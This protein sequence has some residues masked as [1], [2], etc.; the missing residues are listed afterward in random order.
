MLRL[1]LVATICFAAGFAVSSFVHFIQLDPS[2]VASESSIDSPV[3]PT[4]SSEILPAASSGQVGDAIPTKKK[5]DELVLSLSQMSDAKTPFEAYQQ[6][7]TLNALSESELK[8]ALFS[9]AKDKKGVRNNIVWMLATKYPNNA[10]ALLME[11]VGRGERELARI[12]VE[13]LSQVRPK[14]A[15]QWLKENDA[16][17]EKMV[18]NAG[19]RYELKLIVLNMLAKAPEYKWEAYDEAQ[20][21]IANSPKKAD[22]YQLISLAQSAASLDPEEA[23]NRA[24]VGVDGKKDSVLFNGALNV[25]MGRDLQRAREVIELNPKLAESW[26]IGQVLSKM[27]KENQYSD[28]YSFANSFKDN[29]QRRQVASTLGNVLVNS[30]VDRVIE[31]A[32]T[33]KA[34]DE[35]FSMVS[36]AVTTMVVN[37]APIKDRLNL[38]D[39]TLKT[40]PSE[41]KVFTYAMALKEWYASGS[42]EYA[43]YLNSVRS[44]DAA[45]AAQLEKS[46]TYFPK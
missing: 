36:A 39:E 1:V 25:L 27:V 32:N 31:F 40:V 35:K 2:V 19:D 21:M 5:S 44:R 46:M 24:L 6:L 45:F 13:S 11:L 43:S 37:G 8:T 7:F 3:Q 29:D 34:D 10:E 15:W 26:S 22:K 33:L 30:G 9:V 28:S 23:L 4:K 38:L 16:L 41:K 18:V 14:Q 42:T 17:V 12:A 20:A